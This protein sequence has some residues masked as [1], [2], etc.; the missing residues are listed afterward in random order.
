MTT[1]NYQFYRWE[2]FPG[3]G[4]VKRIT[5]GWPPITPGSDSISWPSPIGEPDE[6]DMETLDNLMSDQAVQEAL[7]EYCGECRDLDMETFRK[8]LVHRFE[9]E[10]FD[11][12]DAG[13]EFRDVILETVRQGGAYFT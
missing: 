13:E 11:G 3:F 6:D 4:I 10:E 8:W 1:T 9:T 12:D 7:Y 2:P 5:T